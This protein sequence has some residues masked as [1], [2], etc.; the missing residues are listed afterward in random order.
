MP[1][2]AY[3]RLVGLQTS[4]PDAT[5]S[6]SKRGVPYLTWHCYSVAWFKSTR[7]YRLF[8]PQSG[9]VDEGKRD[10]RTAKELITYLRAH[11]NPGL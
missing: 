1:R 8:W 6:V 2:S 4:L 5:V 3:S 9:M 11:P 7:T 10:F